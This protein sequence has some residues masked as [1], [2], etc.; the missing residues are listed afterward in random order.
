M[1]VPLVASAGEHLHA[2]RI[3][4]RHLGVEQRIDS[5][6]HRAPGVPQEL[7]P[8][9][10]VDED[11]DTREARMSSRSPSQ[12]DPRMRR[13]SSTSIGSAASDRSAKFTAARFESRW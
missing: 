13:A 6:A 4:R 8:R 3:A 1:E 2:H 11:H 10:R 12:P 7:H 5:L 9:R